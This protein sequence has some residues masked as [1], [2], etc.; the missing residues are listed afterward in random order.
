MRQKG[1]K[2]AIKS[3][4]QFGKRKVLWDYAY[5]QK[6]DNGSITVL[7]PLA[8]DDE[9]PI[10]TLNNDKNKRNKNGE[11]L[12]KKLE[13]SFNTRKIAI[14]KY[15][16]GEIVTHLLTYIYDDEKFEKYKKTSNK[17]SGV[18]I[19]YDWEENFKFGNYYENGTLT[20]RLIP[21]ILDKKGAKVNDCYWIYTD[22]YYK[23]C[24]GGDCSDWSY[25]FSS[26]DYFCFDE[27]SSHNYTYYFNPYIPFYGGTPTQNYGHPN[28]YK[29]EVINSSP[30]EGYNRMWNLQTAGGSGTSIELLGFITTDDKVIIAPTI[31]NTFDE[32]V[33]SNQYN[34]LI[35]QRILA[36]YIE[37]NQL[38]LELYGQD[39]YSH[40]TLVGTYTIKGLVHTHPPTNFNE[41]ND[42]PSP[43]DKVLAGSSDYKNLEHYIIERNSI[44]KY[45]QNGEISRTPQNCY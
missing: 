3:K 2:I 35:G 42:F 18:I 21:Q 39:I 5:S 41:S 34:D 17:F 27:P 25:N 10:I 43:K 12:D 40:R 20:K 14:T 16:N 26:G 37:N 38:K 8:L 4:S 19:A 15:G 32:A 31:G 28:A 6:N 24:F 11:K 36:T 9:M 13:R 29:F 1:A 33:V 30:C 23:V 45:N 22:Y 7:A 44:I